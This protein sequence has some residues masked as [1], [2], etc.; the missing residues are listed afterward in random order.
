ME[1]LAKDQPD[2]PGES[3]VSVF[4]NGTEMQIHRGSHTGADLKRL[5]GVEASMQLDEDVNGT[6]T[7]IADDARVTIKGGERFFRHVPSGGS[8]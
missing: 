7:P 3:F 2:H 6:L 8:A 4:I 1:T 5:L